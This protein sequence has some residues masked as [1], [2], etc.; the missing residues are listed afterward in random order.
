MSPLVGSILI[1]LKKKRYLV[2][3]YNILI[4][5]FCID[6]FSPQHS[7]LW[8]HDVNPESRLV[9]LYLK[10]FTQETTVSLLSAA[11]KISVSS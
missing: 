10:T 7:C 9:V 6:F 4:V 11:V 1:Y 5:L 8:M 2:F 3:L